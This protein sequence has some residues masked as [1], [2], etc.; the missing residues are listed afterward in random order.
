MS[1]HRLAATLRLLDWGLPTVQSLRSR[2]IG[3]RTASGR[4]LPRGRRSTLPLRTGAQPGVR[5]APKADL[6]RAQLQRPTRDRQLPVRSWRRLHRK[7]PVDQR[8]PSGSGAPLAG[9]P[10][11]WAE[12][13]RKAGVPTPT[14]LG[15]VSRATAGVRCHLRVTPVSK[16]C[17]GGPLSRESKENAPA[18]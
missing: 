12:D 1:I 7:Q 16:P 18:P 9:G 13:I 8:Q 14:T 10:G 15:T 17:R 2:A 5:F 11:P 6:V 4:L 3:Q